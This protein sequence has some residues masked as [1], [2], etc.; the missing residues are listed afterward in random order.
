MNSKK[1]TPGEISSSMEKIRKRYDEYISKFF[2]PRSLRDAFEGRY[3]KALRAGIDVSS[4]LLAEISAIEELIAREE[5]RVMAGPPRASAEKEPSF[6]D[7]ILE[8]NRKRIEKYPDVPFH[9]DAGEEVRRLV[10]ALSGLEKDHWPDLTTALRDTMYA[11]SSAEML[12]LDSQLRFLASTNREEIPQF[13]TRLVSQLG[14]F[15]RNYAAIDREE[16]EYILEAGFFLNDLITV[17]ERVQR[18]YTEMGAQEKRI[19]DEKKAIIWEIINDFRLK[20]FKRRRRWDREE[21]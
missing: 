8:E 19:L 10:G 16:K 18:V 7:K 3:I 17:L 21:S 9:N 12:S 1:L 14:K 20:D 2:K 5:Q 4:F 6:A 11:M 13:L 15:P